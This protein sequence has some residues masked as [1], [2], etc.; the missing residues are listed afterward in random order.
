MLIS[1]S[2]NGLWLNP[3]R[4]RHLLLLQHVFCQ[5]K[6]QAAGRADTAMV[7]RL[8]LPEQMAGDPTCAPLGHPATADASKLAAGGIGNGVRD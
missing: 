4:C 3:I 5:W 1:S 8:G 2:Q 7:N 6:A